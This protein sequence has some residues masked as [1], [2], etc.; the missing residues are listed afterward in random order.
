MSWRPSFCPWISTS[1]AASSLSCARRDGRA[2]DA[3]AA[4]PVCCYAALDDKLIISFYFIVGQPLLTAAH[5]KRG[6]D[7][8][9]IRTAADKLTAHAV[10][11][12]SAYRVNDN[13][14]TCTGLT[15]QHIEPLPNEISARSMTAIFSICSSLSMVSSCLESA[16]CTPAFY[17]S[18]SISL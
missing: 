7:K 4:F 6:G 1:S 11:K 5:I 3:A 10:A 17:S 15:G 13:G 12:N 2:A 9:L 8:P 16:L 14:F 18:S